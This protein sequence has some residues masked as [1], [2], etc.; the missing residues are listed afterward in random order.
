MKNVIY[1]DTETTGIR[2]DEDR[3]VEI[4]GFDPI[5]KR[6]F[7]AFV[8]PGI[9][10]PPDATR[11][12]G[13]S[14]E[15]VKDA[16]NFQQVGQDF[17][18]FC[19]QDAILIAHNN[20]GFD[21][22][23]MRNELKRHQLTMP[24]WNFIDTLKW[25]R[26][27]RSD[28]PRHSLQFLREIYGIAKNNAHRALD[29]VIVLHDV[30]SK[31]IDDLTY[32]QVL[33]LLSIKKMPKVMKMLSEMPFGK[34]QGVALEKVPKNYIQWLAESGSLEKEG[35]LELKESLSKLGLLPV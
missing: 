14:D 2:L 1:Y 33:G 31:M 4:A 16:P 30:F 9:P 23:I 26:R 8:H 12:H 3:I 25:A 5:N 13:I 20:D 15:M 19:G 29:D 10:I 24:A 35:N 6:T 32:E 21:L 11:I 18:D 17:I 27:Y 34:H 28:L 22:H 7:C